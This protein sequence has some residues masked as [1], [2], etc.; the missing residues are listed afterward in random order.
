MNPIKPIFLSILIIA[1]LI[2]SSVASTTAGSGFTVMSISPSKIISNDEDLKTANFIVTVVANGNSQ[3]IIGELLTANDI[4]AKLSESGSSV[5]VS[6]PF[7]IEM[8]SVKETLTYPIR[9]T[10][11]I[12]KY[13][14]AYSSEVNFVSEATC[15]SGYSYCYTVEAGSTWWGKTYRS[16]NIRQANSAVSSSL[17]ELDNP[18]INW[19]GDIVLTAGLTR[20]SKT[21]GSIESLGAA[22]FYNSNEWIAQATWTGSLLTGQATPNPSLY[23]ATFTPAFNQWRISSNSYYND[24]ASSLSAKQAYFPSMLSQY[25]KQ[26]CL[27]S[28]GCP[29]ETP[30]TNAISNHNSIV[31]I[32]LSQNTKVTYTSSTGETLAQSTSGTSYSG[33]VIETTN[34]RI[35]N[36]VIVFKVKALSLSPYIP[37]GKPR[38]E[39]ITTPEFSS[40]DNNGVAT[41]QF[42]N[43]GTE[44]ATFSA[45][46][47][48]P[49]GTFHPSSNQESSKTT[50]P[51]LSQCI[52][53]VFI[54]SDSPTNDRISKTATMTVYDINKPSNSDTKTFDIIMSPPKTCIPSSTRT[55]GKLI[56]TCNADGSGETV[57]ECTGTI[58]L[59]NSKYICIGGS[60]TPKP[61]TTPVPKTIFATLSDFW[62]S[63]QLILTVLVLLIL[64]SLIYIKYK[65]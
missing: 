23:K 59:Q 4:N 60:V 25:T 20:V 40:G 62:S 46:F 32:L 15:L 51:A 49:S 16:L 63:P 61:G 9:N 50:C 30:L 64:S 10:G 33:N 54:S 5:R 47:F 42:K 26:V 1:I 41:V 31:D 2:P 7:K 22:D 43:I 58:S 13:E 11:A 39:S 53:N 8:G 38:I 37:V 19:Q 36:P 6:S 18:N 44:S 34:R 52:I 35:S 29:S 57:I 24:Y 14:Y 28:Y 21:I 12:R 45:T 56:Y 27:D 48:D 65:K 55:S 3:S 17:G